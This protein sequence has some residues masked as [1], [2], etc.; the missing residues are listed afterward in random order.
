M[1]EIKQFKEE[2]DMIQRQFSLQQIDKWKEFRQRRE[3]EISKYLTIKRHIYKLK[4][5]RAIIKQN[6]MV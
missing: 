4:F 3:V 1:K 2:V 6:F 5:I